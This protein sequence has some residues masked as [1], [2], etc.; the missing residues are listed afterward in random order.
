M[1]SKYL[2]DL[3]FKLAWKFTG[4]LPGE[5]ERDRKEVEGIKFPIVGPSP[6]RGKYTPPIEGAELSGPYLYILVDGE[7]HP[8]YVGIATES[9]LSSPIERWIRPDK[10]GT[11]E[12]WA[13]GTN[14]K[15]GKATVVW[16]KE[17]LLLGYGP[18]SLYFSN[19][20]HLT[21]A[22][23]TS[24]ERAGGSYSPLQQLP[25]K[26]FIEDLEHALIFALQPEWNTQKKR[27][28]PPPTMA[29]AVSHWYAHEQTH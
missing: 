7:G 4:V 28:P 18:Y 15:K 17:G 13:H 3:G 8:K 16:L 1:T 20:A 24:I 5:F 11:A 26:Q 27:T 29:A 14:K 12:H 10:F 9:G 25:A 22:I 6:T 19:Y 2:T 21:S 23:G